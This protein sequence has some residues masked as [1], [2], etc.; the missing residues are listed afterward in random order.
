ME[1][2]PAHQGSLG[3]EARRIRAHWAA[4]PGALGLIGAH[5]LK[6]AQLIG[7][8][9]SIPICEWLCTCSPG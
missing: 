7:A 3:C 4:R 1:E 9:G 5:R 2:G 6:E 8:G